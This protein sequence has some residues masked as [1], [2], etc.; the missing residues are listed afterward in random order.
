MK[1]LDDFIA[2]NGDAIIAHSRSDETRKEF[3]RAL[4]GDQRKDAL[5]FTYSSRIREGYFRPPIA[6]EDYGKLSPT[7]STQARGVL[8]KAKT[9]QERDKVLQTWV[10]EMSGRN[11]RGGGPWGGRMPRFAPASPDELKKFLDSLPD[12]ERDKLWAMPREE[13]ERTLQRRY[14]EEK[15]LQKFLTSLPKEEQEKLRGMKEEDR[16]K[17]LQR[18]YWERFRPRGGPPD[19]RDRRPDRRDDR[20][21]RRDERPIT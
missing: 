16:K 19:R 12:A 14:W 10:R 11:M 1:W 20:R 4:Q 17:E 13:M 9:T 5:R 2:R 15:E 3:L 18:K 21:E 7:L 8:A 6:D